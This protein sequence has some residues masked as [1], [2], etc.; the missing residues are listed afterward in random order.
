MRKFFYLVTFLLA[1]TY[2]ASAQTFSAGAFAGF[3]TNPDKSELLRRDGGEFHPGATA[4]VR[5]DLPKNVAF[6]V[7]GDLSKTPQLPKLFTTDEGEHAPNYEARVNPEATVNFGKFFAGA[8]VDLFYH[9]FDKEPGEEYTRS[10]GINPTAT[11]GVDFAKNHEASFTYL[12]RDKGTDLYGYRASYFFDVP[13]KGSFGLRFGVRGN[14]LTFK[15]R[16]REGYIDPYYEH[17]FTAQG[18]V[19][20]TF[21]RGK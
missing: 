7:R 9:S 14:Y 6:K 11:V 1:F 20:L 15:E 8:G 5:F 19:E 13:I 4:S 17:D 21:K 3:T 12:F 16:N 18:S 2:C 10:F